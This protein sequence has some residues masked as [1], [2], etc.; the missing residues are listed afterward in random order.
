MLRKR[1][2]TLVELLVVIAIIT[3][4]AS[5]VVPRVQNWIGRARMTKAVTEIRNADLALT[6]MLADADK[7]GFAQFFT[8]FPN[9]NSLEA[10]LDLYSKAMTEL[11]RRGKEAYLDDLGLQLR[12]EVKK[13]LGTTYMDI[14]TDP[15]RTY[16]YQ[17]YLGPLK[18]GD[19]AYNYFR[20]YREPIEGISQNDFYEYTNEIFVEENRKLRGNPPPDGLPGYPAPKD[21]SVYIFSRGGDEAINQGAVLGNP[22]TGGGDDINNWDNASGWDGAY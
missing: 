21:L 5:I 15:W 17:F 1:G 14:G 22:E 11:L 6:K 20:S 16:G 12:P 3:I 7:K 4:L 2:F 18:S 13:K 9:L 10:A 8:G 19:Y